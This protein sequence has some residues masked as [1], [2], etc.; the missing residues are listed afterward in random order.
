MNKEYSSQK[1]KIKGREEIRAL[2]ESVRQSCGDIIGLNSIRGISSER[3]KSLES[4]NRIKK[5]K[6]VGQ[7]KDDK[8]FGS[9]LKQ[10]A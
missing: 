9:R 3:V 7:R 2:I 4:L 5:A 1:I 10:L 8:A 6:M